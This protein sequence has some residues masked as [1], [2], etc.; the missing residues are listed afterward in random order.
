MELNVANGEIEAP[1]LMITHGNE[2]EKHLLYSVSEKRFRKINNFSVLDGKK[3]LSCSYGWLILV[4]SVANNADCCLYNPISMDTIELPKLNKG[5]TYVQGILT[6][7]PT[8]PDCNYILFIDTVHQSFC[9][10]KDKQYVSLVRVLRA[11]VSFQGNTCG[12]I[13]L[14][15]LVTI[16]FVGNTVKFR[17]ILLMDANGEHPWAIPHSSLYY[18]VWL[19]E[20]P[21]D[22]GGEL[23]MV[24]KILP[25]RNGM[26]QGLDF[27]VSCIDTNG[28]KC[29]EVE[30]IGKRTIFLSHDGGGYCCPSSKG[31]K[32]NT[33]YYTNMLDRNLYTFD[34]EDRSTTSM[35]LSR[36]IAANKSIT[37]WA[38][39]IFP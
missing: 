25:S 5:Y 3:V 12:F 7:P 9:R 29:T 31:L 22:C 39:V 17:R 18:Y 20:S 26:D 13:D 36:S 33:I 10:I 30:N 16:D 6:K 8:E 24:Q 14:N 34:L 4:A 15:L 37:S 32:S 23:L 27:V 21:N 35:L 2:F 38:N 19:I 11:V 28:M 1:F